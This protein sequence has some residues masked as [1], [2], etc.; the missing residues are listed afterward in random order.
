MP[1]GGSS[2]SK[3]GLVVAVGAVPGSRASSLLHSVLLPVCMYLAFVLADL[4]RQAAMHSARLTFSL[5][6]K[7]DAKKP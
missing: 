2:G 7:I 4:W 1:V 3:E 5:L 6:A